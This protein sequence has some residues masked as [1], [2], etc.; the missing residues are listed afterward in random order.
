VIS[1]YLSK[2]PTPTDAVDDVKN[3]IDSAQDLP[4]IK[5]N[6]NEVFAEIIK[7]VYALGK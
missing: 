7:V 4:Q 3:K 5:S 1:E 2:Y 6:L